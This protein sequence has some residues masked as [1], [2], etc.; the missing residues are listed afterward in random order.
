MVGLP[1]EVGNGYVTQFFQI[2]LYNSLNVCVLL[3]DDLTAIVNAF[4]K[5]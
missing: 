4:S 2:K 1:F 3:H 5:A